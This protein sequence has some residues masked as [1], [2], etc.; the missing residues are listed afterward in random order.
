[1]IREAAGFFVLSFLPKASDSG[2][3]EQYF[4]INHHK[5]N[6]KIENENDL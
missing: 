2:N 6:Y 5:I 1:M 3:N 4:R